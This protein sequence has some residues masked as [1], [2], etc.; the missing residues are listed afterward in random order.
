LG[1]PEAGVRRVDDANSRETG[2]IGLKLKESATS[3]NRTLKTPDEKEN[4]SETSNNFGADL[5]DQTQRRPWTQY[6]RIAFILGCILGIF[7]AWAAR[8]PDIQLDGLLESMDM[9]DFFDDLKAALPSTLPIGLVRE[10][11]E[12]Q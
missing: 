12:I 8:S 3:V 2:I 6:R 4:T 9:A 11:R 7:L 10:A 5:V 1:K